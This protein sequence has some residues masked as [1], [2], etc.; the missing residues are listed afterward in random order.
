MRAVTE[1]RFRNGLSAEQQFRSENANLF[2]KHSLQGE[3]L[4][5][6]SSN[7]L[8]KAC[9]GAENALTSDRVLQLLIGET[10]GRMAG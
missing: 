7:A 5:N 8:A 6:K 9:N 1:A 3:R 2:S 10:H 4:P